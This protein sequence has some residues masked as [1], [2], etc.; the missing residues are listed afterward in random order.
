VR[1]VASLVPSLTELLFALDL[2]DSIV[3]RTGFCIH[4][5]GKVRRI[6][7]V[8]G[9][10]DVDLV[11]VIACKPTHLVVNIDENDREQV[12]VLRESIPHVV[13]TH[14]LCPD[15]NLT[16]YREFGR[17]FDRA[18]RAQELATQYSQARH[19][20][21]ARASE[22][23]PKSVLYLIWKDP[24]FTIS[25]PTYISAMLALANL[26]SL[27][28][29][30]TARYPSITDDDA[31]WQ[32]A[33]AILLSSEPY[34][35]RTRHADALAGRFPGKPILLVDGELLSWYGSRVIEGLR[36]LEALR[37]QIDRGLETA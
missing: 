4:P 15:D 27:P 32:Q 34:A 17:I 21:H 24:W 8:G 13:V 20:I 9:T 3:A 23:R 36:Y 33:D 6:P 5:R 16:L 22:W 18:D 35:F 30:S 37:V 12:A 11:K 14:P 31:A 7:K 1:R 28:V 26:R 29:R 10:K 19:E 2:G 25:P